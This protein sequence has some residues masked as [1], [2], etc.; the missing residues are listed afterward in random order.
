MTRGERLAQTEA[1]ARA[2]LGADR[3]RLKQVQAH[4]RDAE[5]QAVHRRRV[6]GGELVQEAGAVGPPGWAPGG[7]LFPPPPPPAGSASLGPPPCPPPRPAGPPPR[8]RAPA[9][10]A[11]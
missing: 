5:R 8:S 4:Q 3:S 11:A 10:P 6:L 1:H 7:G 9:V 2:K